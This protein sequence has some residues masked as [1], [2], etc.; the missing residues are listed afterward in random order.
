LEWKPSAVSYQLSAKKRGLSAR[1]ERFLRQ[2]QSCQLPIGG[3][4]PD[5]LR[6][7]SPRLVPCRPDCHKAFRPVPGKPDGDGTNPPPRPRPVRRA[8]P[9]IPREERLS[10]APR[11]VDRGETK[12]PA[13]FR[14]R[15]FRYV[16]MLTSVRTPAL[17]PRVCG[18]SI[19]LD[20]N[21]RAIRK[22]PSLFQPGPAAFHRLSGGHADH[23]TLPPGHVFALS[24]PGFRERFEEIG[25][26][27]ADSR[28]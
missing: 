4:R 14:T 17:G 20:R 18:Q 7:D 24:N 28:A 25:L 23:G 3:A 12:N 11:D 21:P 1:V 10:A 6:T 15:G 5:S 19:R 8:D 22:A 9:K 26:D 13:S 27:R 16:A 2:L